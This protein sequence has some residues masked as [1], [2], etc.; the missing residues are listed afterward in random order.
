MV[1][2]ISHFYILAAAKLLVGHVKAISSVPQVFNFKCFSKT[3]TVK[4]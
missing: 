3:K 4:I 1:D 2:L